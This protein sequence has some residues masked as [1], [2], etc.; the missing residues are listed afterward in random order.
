VE[1]VEG[2]LGDL[3]ARERRHC[4]LA[5]PVRP[6]AGALRG[7]ILATSPAMSLMRAWGN[8]VPLWLWMVTQPM[9][10]AFSSA[11]ALARQPCQPRRP[12]W[13]DDVVCGFP[14]EAA[15]D[16]GELG[17]ELLGFVGFDLPAEGGLEQQS[18]GC[19]GEERRSRKQKL[20]LAIDLDQR[21]ILSVLI[22]LIVLACLLG[23]ADDLAL[24]DGARDKVAV[25]KRK[26]TDLESRWSCLRT[27]AAANPG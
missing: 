17:G 21:L 4:A 16:V 22:V 2:L 26:V 8:S 9:R 23:G 6:G 12:H 11:E 14:T 27:S 13:G 7:V 18:V 19:G 5:I 25:N 20:Q 3:R 15:G 1:V 10:S 24:N